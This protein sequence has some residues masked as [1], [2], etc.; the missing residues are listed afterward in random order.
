[1]QQS[2]QY[3]DSNSWP[4]MT[5]RSGHL[6]EDYNQLRAIVYEYN[7]NILYVIL[8]AEERSFHGGIIM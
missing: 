2:M 4:A 1:M 6:P 3:W 7:Y 8:H 5:T